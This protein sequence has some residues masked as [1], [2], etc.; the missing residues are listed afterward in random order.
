M[1]TKERIGVMEA[2][3]EG[4]EIQFRDH[5]TQEW[6]DVSG[7]PIWDWVN[8]SYRIKPNNPKMVTVYEYMYF[9]GIRWTIINILYKNDD[10][11]REGWKGYKIQKTGVE[12][13]VEEY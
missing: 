2:Y 7:E 8:G 4:S 1:T 5:V 6:E 10:E 13:Q 3:E 11:A 9:N 12:F